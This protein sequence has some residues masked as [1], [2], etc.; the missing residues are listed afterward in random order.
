VLQHIESQ[1]DKDVYLTEINA[2]I[3]SLELRIQPVA[4]GDWGTLDSD[5][6]FD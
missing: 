2:N 4:G 3:N 5:L 6:F 1:V